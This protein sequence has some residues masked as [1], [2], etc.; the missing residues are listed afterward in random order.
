[1]ATYDPNPVND[2]L[3]SFTFTSISKSRQIYSIVEPT[4][5]RLDTNVHT[6]AGSISFYDPKKD[7]ILMEIGQKFPQRL[8]KDLYSSARSYGGFKL[9]QPTEEYL[10]LAFGKDWRMPKKEGWENDWKEN[11]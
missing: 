10:R 5:C 11:P 8:F 3:C 1:M 7:P 2:C 4:K 9:P 6:V